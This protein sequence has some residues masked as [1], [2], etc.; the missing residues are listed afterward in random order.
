M[1]KLSR[2]INVP[3]FNELSTV[4]YHKNTLFDIPQFRQLLTS[5][6]NQPLMRKKRNI[7]P[8]NLF[9]KPKMR[10]YAKH[11]FSFNQELITRG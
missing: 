11:M 1:L 7:K 9:L 3:F 8:F 5:A 10:K 4:K 6:L 2:D